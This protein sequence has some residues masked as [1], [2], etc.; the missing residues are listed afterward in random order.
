[1][2]LVSQNHPNAT[3]T[4]TSTYIAGTWGGNTIVKPRDYVVKP[5]KHILPA[6]TH[7]YPWLTGGDFFQPALTKLD[8]ILDRDCSF[9]GNLTSTARDADDHNFILPLEPLC[10]KYL[11]VSDL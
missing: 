2:P 10:F 11:S 3:Q 8:H 6:T 4:D 7:Q 5:G 9:N 1:M